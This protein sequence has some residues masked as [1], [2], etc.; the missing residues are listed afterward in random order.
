M[1]LLSLWLRCA[2]ATLL[3]VG[4]PQNVRAQN[5]SNLRGRVVDESGRPVSFAQLEL[6]P[7]NRRV[8][9]DQSGD[10]SINAIEDGAYELRVRRIGYEPARLAIRFPYGQP[11]ITISLTG[12]P[13]VLDSVRIRERSSPRYTGIVLD[14]FEQPVVGAEVI[15]AGASDND[16]RTN[17]DGHFRLE[18]AQK[19][20][21]LLRVRK[22]GYT[23]YFGSLT[24]RAEREDT[25]R[26]KRLPQ[27]LPEAYVLIESGFD[28]DTFVYRELD[29][30]MRWKSNLAGIASREDMDRW[31]DMNLC[32]ALMRTGAAASMRLVESM[33]HQPACVLIDGKDLILRPLNAFLAKEVEAF[34]Y[35]PRDQTGTIASRGKC[36]SQFIP[37]EARALGQGGIVVWLRRR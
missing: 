7:A 10:F 8:V 36:I 37:G 27:G 30:R 19:G 6:S 29:S 33:C 14:D 11:S 17:S 35:H 22:P 15:P 12:L 13:R 5:L 32:Q 20:T 23:P 9:A 26:M 25:L 3:F 2:F 34:E 4:W 31:A 16:V 21:L 18:K 24:F 28:R 1:I